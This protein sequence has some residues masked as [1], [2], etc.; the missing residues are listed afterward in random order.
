M[1]LLSKIIARRGE[2]LKEKHLSEE[3]DIFRQNRN[4]A[5]ESFLRNVL[6]HSYGDSIDEIADAAKKSGIEFDTGASYRLLTIRSDLEE[7]LKEYSKQELMFIF[8][9]IGREIIF[10]SEQPESGRCVEAIRRS[11]YIAYVP[12]DSSIQTREELGEKCRKLTEVL[13][14]YM[15]FDVL[16]VISEP[17][18]ADKLANEKERAD[19][20]LSYNL[21]CNQP[22][23]FIDELDDGDALSEGKINQQEITR[24]LRERRKNELFLYMRSFLEQQGS[25]LTAADMKILHH[26]LMQVFYGYLYENNISIHDFMPDETSQKI[27]LSAEYSSMDMMKYVSYMYDC[28]VSFIDKAKKS[29]S[30]IERAKKYISEHFAENIGRTEI[31]QEVLLAPNYLS[32]IFHKETGQTIR[33]YI[34]LC[35]VEEAKRLFSA[36]NY[37]VTDI[38]LQIG[39]DNISYFSTI[40]K[41]Y[42]GQSPLEYRNQLNGRQGAGR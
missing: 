28:V 42:T 24:F 10:G 15:D 11:S 2:K 38:A 5:F 37:S 14:L 7:S 20:F 9:N 40:F 34:N 30:V 35:R 1:A 21:S 4:F 13:K 27:Q 29:D 18:T 33:E 16:C 26:D 17:V 19:E 6:D 36:T 41:K 25:S 8:R 3:L 39:F 23:V 12:V 31:A 22:V 32:M